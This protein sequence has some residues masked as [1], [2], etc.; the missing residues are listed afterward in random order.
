VPGKEQQTIAAATWVNTKF[1]TRIAS[2]LAALRAFI[3]GPPLEA[4]AG[5]NKQLVLDAVLRDF[6]RLMG[7]QAKPLFDTFYTWP[8]S[9]PQFAVGHQARIERLHSSLQPYTGLSL[10][11][12]Y[13]DGVGIPDSIRRAK[14]VAKHI[15]S[16]VV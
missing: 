10:T 1:P 16:F 7:I 6:K 14:E 4:L 2:G 3:V 9:M 11:G 5:L 12:N 15:A 8:L 13:F